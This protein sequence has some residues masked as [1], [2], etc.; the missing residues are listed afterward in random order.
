[1][2]VDNCQHT[3][4]DLTETKFPK[5]F[6]NLNGMIANPHHVGSFLVKKKGIKTLLKEH[7]RNEDF[8]G[9]YVLI[10][11]SKPYYVGISRKVFRRLWYHC[12]GTKDYTATLAYSMASKRFSIDATRKERMMNDEFLEQFDFAKKEIQKSQFAYVEI[13]NDFEL[14]VFEAF[15]AL[16]LD[17]SLYNS[18]RTS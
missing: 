1:M 2:P 14:Y 5:Y 11:N 10:K 17:T 16:T 7:G 3:F 13:T 9:C 4:H 12:R 8:Q 15:A 6:A 18:F